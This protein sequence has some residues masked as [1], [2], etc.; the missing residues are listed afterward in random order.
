ML[1]DWPQAPGLFDG[2]LSAGAQACGG[3]FSTGE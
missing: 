1:S 3:L 2:K